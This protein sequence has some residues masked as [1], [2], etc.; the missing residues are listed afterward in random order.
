MLVKAAV[1]MPSAASPVVALMPV[2]ATLSAWFVGVY[3]RLR[4]V[5]RLDFF[6]LYGIR[7]FASYMSGYGL[8]VRVD[9]FLRL[10]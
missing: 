3:I 5:L 8:V 4:V 1:V 10:R 7:F 9:C 2:S 6:F